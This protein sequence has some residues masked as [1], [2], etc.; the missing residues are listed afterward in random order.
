MPSS[1]VEIAAVFSDILHSIT[2]IPGGASGVDAISSSI[3]TAP[4]GTA[5]TLT[6]TLD[7][8]RKVSLSADGV[9]FTPDVISTS[10]G[11][12]TFTMPS[13][14]V[15]IA[16][17]FSDIF[18]SIT[19]APSGAVG[20]D[21]VGTS[22]GNAAA[23]TTITLTA[24]LD[25]GRKVTLSTSDVSLSTTIMRNSG[26]TAT[27]TMPDFNVTVSSTFEYFQ[28]GDT[29]PEGGVIFY[30]DTI[31]FDF[32]NSGS[33]GS[34]EMD[35]LDGNNNGTVASDRFLEAAPSGWNGGTEPMAA[36]GPNATDTSLANLEDIS[37]A[38]LAGN[39]GN[40]ENNTII[41]A[42]LGASYEAAWLCSSYGAGWFLPSLG[43]LK[44]MSES[45]DLID[46]LESQYLSSSEYDGDYVWAMT[47]LDG[48]I[49]GSMKDPGGYF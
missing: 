43:E 36:W 3:D 31:G 12:S 42:G 40:G 23:G 20:S 16:A 24:T 17:A 7:T 15:E 14:D 1:D 45:K 32:D 4:A 6:A 11:T 28:I 38:G 22:T 5:I 26:E 27:F 33:I 21:A 35:L 10:G 29:G 34:A 30:D 13:S 48:G 25:T 49:I 39:V 18:H 44:L 8:E 37:G 19:I 46:G 2:L 47:F 41:L 9:T